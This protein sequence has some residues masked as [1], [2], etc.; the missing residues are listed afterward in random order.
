MLTQTRALSRMAHSTPIAAH[1]P[2]PL[3]LPHAAADA[4]SSPSPDSAA[5]TG[6][7]A[8]AGASTGSDALLVITPVADVLV[9]VV[10]E[11]R[12]LYRGLVGSAGSGASQA[13][14]GA[15]PAP[16]AASWGERLTRYFYG[17][18]ASTTATSSPAT[19]SSSP[20]SPPTLGSL[21]LAA[22]CNAWLL[23]LA[24]PA[25]QRNAFIERELAASITNLAQDARDIDSSAALAVVSLLRALAIEYNDAM[26]MR[27]SKAAR[28]A[29]RVG[30][31]GKAGAS[32]A[33]A[34]AGAGVAGSAPLP[35][36]LSG[37]GGASAAAV[38]RA[39]SPSPS[40]AAADEPADLTAAEAATVSA[41]STMLSVVTALLHPRKLATNL[42][43]VV[44]LLIT[45]DY[46]ATV[47][48]GLAAAVS[49]DVPVSSSASRRTPS[50][51]LPSSGAA[52]GAGAGLGEAGGGG[53]RSFSAHVVSVVNGLRGVEAIL[54]PFDIAVAFAFEEYLG[55]GLRS[56]GGDSEARVRPA[57]APSPSAG[58]TSSP[59]PADVEGG[60]TQGGA[61]AAA[62]L[63]GVGSRIRF[64]V[65]PQVAAHARLLLTHVSASAPTTAAAASAATAA[66]AGAAGSPVAQP[67]LSACEVVAAGIERAFGPLSIGKWD[68]Y[69]ILGRQ[70]IHAL[71]ASFAARLVARIRSG[72]ATGS[73]ASS[74]A[75]A[76]SAAAVA[77][78]SAPLL[79]PNAAA[80]PALLSEFVSFLAA[81]ASHADGFGYDESPYEYDESDDS[82]GF[83]L[84]YLWRLIAEDGGLRLKE[85]EPGVAPMWGAGSIEFLNM[86]SGDVGGSDDIDV[87]VDDDDGHGDGA[88]AKAAGNAGG[89]EVIDLEAGG[90]PAQGDTGREDE[91]PP[92]AF[93]LD[94]MHESL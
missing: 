90:G 31:D 75:D 25:W 93:I 82:S 28:W 80:D 94:P 59:N 5:A 76:A 61:A 91:L 63:A 50:P 46:V 14:S 20:K 64:D 87:D 39:L 45:R 60:G 23:S 9:R 84:P 2:P 21:T 65:D 8:G 83:F 79:G 4:S 66:T 77:A 55:S 62:A 1:P 33:T 74:A 7:G 29:P 3:P 49:P 57:S 41:L 36:A 58:A 73:P 53:E 67:E 43:L 35:Q 12:G 47:Y 44:E 17:G 32:A 69:G 68:K 30:D 51:P 11:P 54:L 6:A 10:A 71:L 37:K 16:V 42:R 89:F 48:A 88:E 19:S 92:P 78:G 56:Q 70:V 81:H 13:I 40:P 26:V 18:S 15:A 22:L 72:A 24:A 86:A 85:L 38:A 52:V 34:G 27:V